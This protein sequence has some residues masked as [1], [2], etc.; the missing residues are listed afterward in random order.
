LRQFRHYEKKLQEIPTY[1]AFLMGLTNGKIENHL[2][3]IRE[4]QEFASLTLAQSSSASDADSASMPLSMATPPS[5]FSW[6]QGFFAPSG[7]S[8]TE[9]LGRER[10]SCRFSSAK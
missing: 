3:K 6:P 9:K 2:Q 4:S 10:S 7:S 1:S 8:G 5:L